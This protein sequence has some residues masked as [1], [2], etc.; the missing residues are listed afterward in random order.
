MIPCA[1]AG[2]WLCRV[3]NRVTDR[4]NQNTARVTAVDPTPSA[5]PV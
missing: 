3:I 5:P 1:L 4:A 2:Y